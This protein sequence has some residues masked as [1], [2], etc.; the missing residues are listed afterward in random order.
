[1][2]EQIIWRLYAAAWKLEMAHWPLVWMFCIVVYALGGGVAPRTA[3]SACPN[4]PLR[5]EQGLTA[6]PGCMA[7]E[8][9]S[10]PKKF[11]QPAYLP[12]FSRDGE[13]LVTIVQTALAGTP[14]Y[15]YYGGDRY[16]A[17]RGG[18]GWSVA[19]TSPLDPALT[20][21]G[22]RWGS[23][24]AFT[25]NL[26]RWVQL[27]ANQSEYQVGVARLF[28]GGLDGSFTSLSPLLT[29]IDNSGSAE[30]QQAVEDLRVNGGSADLSTVVLQVKMGSTAY[31]PDDPRKETADPE[32]GL[33]R[34][35]YV[36]F[37]DESGQPA[38]ELLAR[39]K[40]GKVWG[41]RCGAHLGGEETTF[42]QG[43]I[44]PDG[45]RIFFTT[46]PAQFW[47][48]E[49]V[50]GPVCDTENGLRILER[51][52]TSEGPVI[53]E[54]APEG[55][56][57]TAEGDDLFQAAS[58]D[59]SKVYFTTTRKLTGTDADAT[60]VGCSASLG[61]SKGCDLYLY[62]ANRPE[63]ERIVHVSAGEGPGPADV[64]NSITGVSGDGSRAFFV[65][66]K[67]LTTDTNPLGASAEDEKPNLYAFEAST[68]EVSFIAT[69]SE[70]D[71]GG[72]QE[73]G[74]LWG[75]KGTLYGDAYSA[76]FYGPGLQGGGDGH[77]LA[78]ASSAPVTGE[79]DDNDGGHRD[80]FRYDADSETLERISKAAS[81]GS[82]N[83]AFDVSVSP[84]W[85]RLLEYNFGNTTR[86][87]SE[88]GEIIAFATAEALHSDDADGFTNPYVWDAGQLGVVPAK[89]TKL[90]AVVKSPAVAP[91]GDQIAF[92]T[93]TA[94]LPR[95]GDVAEDVY[96]ARANGGFPEPAPVVLCNP[97]QE[98]SCQGPPS[99][100]PNPAPPVPTGAPGNVK[101]KPLGKCKKGFVKRK[102]KCVKK[103][104]GKRKAAKRGGHNGGGNR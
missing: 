95:D 92:A 25:P 38:L 78:F 66:Q 33:D 24:A 59:G 94:L 22:R 82:D 39:D 44:S 26:D 84:A 76:P 8:M 61:G 12:S 23:A 67:V 104:K 69:L 18:S 72:G 90:D 10:P 56:G 49:E 42:N 100:T 21:G 48:S 58:A 97:L 51:V 101:P 74:G 98:G 70:G 86:W 65:A 46:R 87:V 50:E 16:V 15:Q 13:R 93:S 5:V 2:S 35:S 81:G 37:R 79:G 53:T 6:L 17:S 41:G 91:V 52:A 1:M 14:G 99:P 54:I 55:G 77:V 11:S 40:D 27:G 85:L 45:S 30:V 62:D 47:D 7:V 64:L 3:S 9:A 28:S 32:P 36:V 63:G 34:N 83:G 57:P 71:E 19:A 4:E 68:E 96:V 43:A 89:L 88:D 103:G 60:T 31:L 102:G 20:A 73:I 29:P 80:V 75:T